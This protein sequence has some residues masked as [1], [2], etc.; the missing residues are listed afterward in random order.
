MKR[1]AFITGESSGIGVGIAKRLSSDGF[2]VAVGYHKNKNLALKIIE[3][4]N[5]TDVSSIAF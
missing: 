5:K 4:I 1:I 3:K 2:F